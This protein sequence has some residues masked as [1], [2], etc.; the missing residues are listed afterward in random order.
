MRHGRII[1][2]LCVLGC[3][4]SMAIANEPLV[5]DVTVDRQQSS[6]KRLPIVREVQPRT[7]FTNEGE[8]RRMPL[9]AQDRTTVRAV[10]PSPYAASQPEENLLQESEAIEGL[11]EGYDPVLALFGDSQ[12]T[13]TGSFLETM[14][15]VP[16]S[17]RSGWSW[18]VALGVAQRLSSG[19]GVRRD[20]F[21]GGR[22][23][24]GGIDIAAAI[25]TP[26]LAA[27]D[28][29]VIEV[30]QDSRFG[31]YVGIRHP[32][33]TISRYGHLSRQ[34]VREGQRVKAASMVGAVGSTGRSTGPHLDFRVSRGGNRFDPLH[35]LSVPAQV[36]MQQSATRQ[37]R[38]G[39][40][41]EDPPPRTRRTASNPLPK[42]PMVIRVQ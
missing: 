22:A 16:G 42:R 26:V 2:L 9:K 29:E 17:G 15:G 25:G 33:G 32:D 12:A 28:G 34:T 30:R 14:R 1:L 13:P 20:P 38:E 4:P 7:T 24:H 35:L 6:G 37:G 3:V 11:N 10:T 27:A 41:T 18:P 8:G 40:R 31:K 5:L 23:F 39:A 19:Y 21:H 36:A